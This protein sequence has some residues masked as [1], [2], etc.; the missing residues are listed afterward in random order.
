M[1]CASSISQK[2]AVAAL[3]GPYDEVE[4]MCQAYRRRRDIA[5][6]VLRRYGLYEYSPKGAFYL[7]VNVSRLGDDA[8]L[9]AKQLLAETGVATAPG[10]AFGGS[11]KG[12]VRISLA[13]KEED[14]RTGLERICRAL[15]GR[16]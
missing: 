9:I 15:T 14:I 11:M 3:R 2:A 12:Y 7:M 13:A 16:A 6:E 5:L 8:S 10:T 4:A 1:S